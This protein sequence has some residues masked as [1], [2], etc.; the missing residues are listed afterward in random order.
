MASEIDKPL[1]ELLPREHHA[2]STGDCPHETQAECDAQL[3]QDYP[4]EP[5]CIC[6]ETNARHC[7]VHND[8]PKWRD[9][10]FHTDDMRSFEDVHGRSG[11]WQRFVEYGALEELRAELRALRHEMRLQVGAAP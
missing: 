2:C 11:R 8:K 1:S 9:G 6:G 5:K 3:A 10:Y 7:P 4:D